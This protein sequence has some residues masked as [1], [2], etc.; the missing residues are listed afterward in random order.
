MKKNVTILV[1]V[2]AFCICFSVT[3]F[4]V[5]TPWLPIQPDAEQNPSNPS[6]NENSNVNNNDNTADAEADGE[7]RQTES[8]TI[9]EAPTESTASEEQGC[10]STLSTCAV[11]A[12]SLA[13]SACV[14]TFGKRE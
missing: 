6:E 4:A 14:I 9:N 3:A 5:S 2:I 12:C 10:G 7:S 13:M 8:A 1:T 11:I